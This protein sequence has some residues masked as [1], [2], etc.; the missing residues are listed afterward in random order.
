[1]DELKKYIK[2]HRADIR[3]GE[4]GI[5]MPLVFE[6]DATTG[7]SVMIGQGKPDAPDQAE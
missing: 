6:H 5:V 7:A 4:G 2:I 3:R 1:L